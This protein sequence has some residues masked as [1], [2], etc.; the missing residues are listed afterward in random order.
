M[1]NIEY[2]SI[3]DVAS[4]DVVAL[5][6]HPKVKAHLIDYDDYNNVS[7]QAWIQEKIK[8][9]AQPGCR[10]RGILRDGRLLGWCGIQL[11]EQRHELA[12]VIGEEAWG[13]GKIIFKD[14]IGWG[15][16]M[17]L[18]YV[19]VHLLETRPEYKFLKKIATSVTRSRLYGRKFT[20][21]QLL[22]R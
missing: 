12:I 21:Y 14:M 2:V 8:V 10:V 15:K 18:E 11:E 7:A 17:N 3:K 20:T 16:E 6:N 5:M 9:D 22:V 1:D 4:E 19:Y 13:I